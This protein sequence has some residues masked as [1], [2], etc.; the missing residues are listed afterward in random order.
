MREQLKGHFWLPEHEDNQIHGIFSMDDQRLM[1]LDLNASFNMKDGYYC[2]VILGMTSKGPVTLVG[3]ITAGQSY[4]IFM[5][6]TEAYK[7]S[8]ALIGS[9]FSSLD[10]IAFDKYEIGLTHL[11]KWV[12]ISNIS[13]IYNEATERKIELIYQAPDNVL[14][15]SI[16]NLEISLVFSLNDS[17][18]NGRVSWEESLFLSIKSLDQS[19]ITYNDLHFKHLSKLRNFFT[20]VIGDSVLPTQII[21][22]DENILDDI[23]VARVFGTKI[24]FRNHSFTETPETIH[25]VEMP[26]P[27]ST[28]RNNTNELINSWFEKSETFAAIFDLFFGTKYNFFLFPKNKFL[29]NMQAL[30]SYHRIAFG[31]GNTIMSSD[32][33]NIFKTKMFELID[34][35]VD[36]DHAQEL[37]DK[38][39]HL[40]DMTLRKRLTELVRIDKVRL[41]RLFK[42]NQNFIYKCVEI[43]NNMTHLD[44][45]GEEEDIT[46]NDWRELIKRTSI[47]LELCFLN[48]LGASEEIKDSYIN[49]YTR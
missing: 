40:N 13:E 11:Q 5:H 20:F 48:E 7:V 26:L 9:H 16:G 41:D 10:D 35:N 47:I 31:P 6:Q 44:N 8:G 45:R 18:S 29:S 12:N 14:L 1:H 39:K 17:R 27:F 28:I 2:E 30:E 33:F 23:D 42:A 24:Y 3:C 49:H 19:K 22:Y 25:A 43:R 4:N 38:L 37:K 34:Q 21:G 46:Q 32:E 15:A 36:V